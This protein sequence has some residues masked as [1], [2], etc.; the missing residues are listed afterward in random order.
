MLFFSAAWEMFLEKPLIG[1]GPAN[2][3][4]ELGSRL[5]LGSAI[6]MPHNVYLW[7]L[8]ETG[9]LGTVPFLAGLWLCWRRGMEGTSW[10]P[11]SVADVTDA[12]PIGHW[13]EGNKLY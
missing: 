13:H 6:G 11:T 9:L 3:I 10:Q 8:T 2:N 12:F 1:W 7:L 5:G 4:S